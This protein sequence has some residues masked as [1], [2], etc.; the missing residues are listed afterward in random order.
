MAGFRDG[1]ERPLDEIISGR[2]SISTMLHSIY[3]YRSLSS[4]R[5]HR[6]QYQGLTSE[7]IKDINDEFLSQQKCVDCD[8]HVFKI[9]M[10]E[11][12]DTWLC[13]DCHTTAVESSPIV[14]YIKEIY[15]G[16]C[17]NCHMKCHTYHMYPKNIFSHV[18]SVMKMVDLGESEEDIRTEISKCN[19][20]CA[21]CHFILTKVEKQLGFTQKKEL[22]AQKF[23]AGEDI[24][25]ILQMSY[26]AYASRMVSV[27]PLIRKK[28][29]RISSAIGRVGS[30]VAE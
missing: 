7:A 21:G 24:S 16:G 13:P 8:R 19:L 15:D 23:N 12:K 3:S 9:I 1:Y 4:R 25:V 17:E 2:I 26:D 6:K 27:Y 30:S 22:V 20:L 5:Q 11:W 28:I 29:C 14:E 18:K 10:K